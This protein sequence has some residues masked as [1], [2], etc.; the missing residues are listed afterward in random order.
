LKLPE[1]PY[2]IL[3]PNWYQIAVYFLKDTIFDAPIQQYS[4]LWERIGQINT[5]TS[6]SHT[7]SDWLSV[8][9]VLAILAVTTSECPLLATDPALSTISEADAIEWAA[10]ADLALSRRNALQLAECPTSS[11]LVLDHI[12]ALYL[13]FRF[14][15]FRN[16]LAAQQHLSSAIGLAIQIGLVSFLAMLPSDFSDKW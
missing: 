1:D 14:E 5:L 12:R 3:P 13:L 8:G 2:Q 9:L 7:S 16:P 10:K 4:K 6:T 11:A 15:R